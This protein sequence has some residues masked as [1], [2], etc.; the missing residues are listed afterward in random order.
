V[1]GDDFFEYVLYYGVVVFDYVLGGFD[2]LCVV[3][4]D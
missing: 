2:V 4:V 1:F 3:E